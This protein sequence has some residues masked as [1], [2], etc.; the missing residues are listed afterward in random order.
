[1][2]FLL[3]QRREIKSLYST[4]KQILTATQCYPGGGNS[5]NNYTIVYTDHHCAVVL[6]PHWN[7][8]AVNC[9]AACEMWVREGSVNSWNKTCDDVYKE[10]CGNRKIT[11]YKKEHCD[12]IL[13]HFATNTTHGPQ[14]RNKC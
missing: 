14:L 8:A 11:V 12:A 10:Q 6:M 5:T 13:S 2:K 3:S 9:K 7:Q 1:M 4:Q